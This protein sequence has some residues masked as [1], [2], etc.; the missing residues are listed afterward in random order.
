M[1]RMFQ[2][3]HKVNSKKKKI[4]DNLHHNRVTCPW[5]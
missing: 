4:T 3:I 1:E 2:I 5:I